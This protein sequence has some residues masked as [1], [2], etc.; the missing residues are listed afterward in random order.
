[1]LFLQEN[2]FQFVHNKCHDYGWA[3]T[4]LFSLDG[5]K[6]GYG[7]VWGK[8]K[9]EDRDTIFEF[10]LGKPYRKL[11]AVF[12]KQLQAM[13]PVSYIECQTN[14]RLLTGLVYEHARNIRAEA[15]LFRDHF[16]TDLQ[17]PGLIFQKAPNPANSRADDLSYTLK[18]GNETVATGGL[19]LNYNFPY[20]D[21]YY[22]VKEEHRRKGYGSFLVQELK[23]A[24]YQAGR[25]P[26]ARCN[27]NNQ[28]SKSALIKAGFG[29][30]GYLLNGDLT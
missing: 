16:E 30:C 21:V 11:S 25:V 13:S 15:I 8:D 29:V 20:A 26:S 18:W 7:A 17:M 2:N 22:E 6:I 28:V 12:F 23:K 27:I 3:D 5:I 4:Y 19:M 1:M 10:Y 9:R 24:A 14:D